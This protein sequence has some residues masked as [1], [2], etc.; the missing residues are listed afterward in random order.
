MIIDTLKENYTTIPCCVTIDYDVCDDYINVSFLIKTKDKS[1]IIDVN[2]SFEDFTQVKKELCHVIT[3]N[4][5]EFHDIINFPCP[6][7]IDDKGVAVGFGNAIQNIFIL[8]YE[9]E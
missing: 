6:L 4:T 7:I 9:E 2:Y 8:L 5:E 1:I 3:L